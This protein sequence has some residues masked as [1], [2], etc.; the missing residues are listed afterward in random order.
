MTPY[1]IYIPRRLLETAW[2]AILSSVNIAER[3][4]MHHKRLSVYCLMFLLTVLVTGCKDDFRAQSDLEGLEILAIQASP[5]SVTLG[6]STNL[7]ALVFSENELPEYQ[8]SVCLFDTGPFDG[9]S[10]IDP[11]LEC[12]IGD[13]KTAELSPDIFVN[14]NQD[15]IEGSDT[16]SETADLPIPDLSTEE[17]M[18][19]LSELE[20][21][22]VRL[23]VTAGSASIEAVKSVTLFKEGVRNTNP[24]FGELTYEGPA[25]DSDEHCVWPED[26]VISVE[27][28]VTLKL[29]TSLTPGESAE[30]DDQLEGS[31]I[32][33]F[34]A[35]AGM[36]ELFSRAD[37]AE[38]QLQIPEEEDLED[39]TVI[40]YL[41]GRDGNG[42]TAWTQRTLQ[43]ETTEEEKD[44]E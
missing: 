40:L 43:V 30:E 15:C 32:A 16:D 14:C 2:T 9:F 37:T 28:G 3:G 19:M 4:L 6:E 18:G 20:E 44:E 36:N 12:C 22:R 5:P 11:A 13:E 24:V 26:T 1:K 38:N 27:A 21:V 35:G 25:C 41:V 34:T 33:W 7:T 39:E 31:S 17:G 8:W 10:C 23:R 42:G 29:K